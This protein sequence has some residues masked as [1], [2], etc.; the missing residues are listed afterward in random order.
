MQHQQTKGKVN[1]AVVVAF[2]KFNGVFLAKISNLSG[3]ETYAFGKTKGKAQVN[4]M[5]NYQ[6]KYANANPALS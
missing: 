2:Q 3:K 6:T 4:A 1:E 5:L